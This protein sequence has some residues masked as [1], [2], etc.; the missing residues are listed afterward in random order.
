MRGSWGNTA[1]DPVLECDG[2]VVL[3]IAHGRLRIAG[4]SGEMSPGGLRG[5]SGTY[6]AMPGTMLQ[7]QQTPSVCLRRS[8]GVEPDWCRLDGVIVVDRLVGR[9]KPTGSRPACKE[10]DQLAV[11]GLELVQVGVRGGVEYRAPDGAIDRVEMSEPQ[12]NFHQSQCGSWKTQYLKKSAPVRLRWS[13]FGI[14]TSR[15]SSPATH[16]S[17][18][19]R[20]PQHLHCRRYSR[21]KSAFRCGESFG[22]AYMRVTAST[23]A[24]VRQ[25]GASPLGHNRDRR[26]K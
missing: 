16:P 24:C 8:A 15:R 9:A 12:L 18:P 4:G 17:S 2:H 6:A 10:H 11:V 7:V 5:R 3:G 20:S 1:L 13:C 22:P 25:F 14:Q 23:C 21:G 19:P 26:S